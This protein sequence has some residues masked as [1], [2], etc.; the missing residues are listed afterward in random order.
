MS[1]ISMLRAQFSD[2]SEPSVACSVMETNAL[3]FMKL[4][5]DVSVLLGVSQMLQMSI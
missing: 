3:L 2:G 1:H 4:N 5:K